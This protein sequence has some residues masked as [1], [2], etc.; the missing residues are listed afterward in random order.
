MDKMGSQ[1]NPLAVP[2]D[3]GWSRGLDGNEGVP[4]S[5]RALRSSHFGGS[6]FSLAVFSRSSVE[7]G[8]FV[9]RKRFGETGTCHVLSPGSECS[10]T[11]WIRAAR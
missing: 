5:P 1:V 8:E 7:R 10:P 4:S 9:D 11:H 2:A 6:N 3:R